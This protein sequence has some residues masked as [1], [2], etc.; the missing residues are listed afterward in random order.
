M[1]WVPVALFACGMALIL[2]EFVVPGAICGIIGTIMAGVGVYLACQAMPEYAIFFIPGALI[3]LVGCVA[4]GMVLLTR[5]RMAS[6]LKLETAQ[7][8]EEG[9]VNE[10]SDL[11]LVG[12]VGEVYSALRPAGAILID[13]H[14]LDAVSDGTFIDKGAK[15]RIVEV[16]G[17]RVV[18]EPA[19]Q[20]V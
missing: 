17:N 2:A 18:V 7:R 15:V 3:A 1:T 19:V 9:W 4:L 16:H 20:A 8:P 11:S 14:R 10:V 12:R 6:V 13:G 5:S